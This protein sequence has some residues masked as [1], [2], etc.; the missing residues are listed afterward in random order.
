MN[1]MEAESQLQNLMLA[2]DL[3]IQKSDADPYDR[4]IFTKKSKESWDQKNKSNNPL[5]GKGKRYADRVEGPD[6]WGKYVPR[7]DHGTKWDDDNLD[8]IW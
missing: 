4:P 8:S 7:A 6:G 1:N 2:G 3:E 5:S